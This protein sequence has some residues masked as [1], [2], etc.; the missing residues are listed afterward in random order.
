MHLKDIQHQIDAWIGLFE[1]GY[2]PPLSNLARLVEEVGELSRAMNH[3][4]GAKTPKANEA[5]TDI[6]EELGDIMFTV[7][8]LANAMDIDLEDVMRTTLDKVI[9]RDST[10]WTIKQDASV[11]QAL[12]LSSGAS[13][14]SAAD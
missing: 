8:V 2:F 11:E 5:P 9:Q 1:E 14:D 7:A 3:R 13:D 4:F 12:S 10:R 6:A